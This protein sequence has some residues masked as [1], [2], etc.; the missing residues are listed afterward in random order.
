VIATVTGGA[1]F[2]GHHLVE[3][4]LAGG[5]RVRV[6]DDLSTGRRARLPAHDPDCELVVASI[7]D[8]AALDEALLGS[9]V[10]FHLAALVSVDQSLVEPGRTNDVNAGGTIEVMRAAARQH[11]HRVVLASSCA[12][13]GCGAQLPSRETQ[14]PEPTSP[15]GVAKLAAEGYL[16]ALGQRHGIATVALRY[17]NVFGEG[18]DPHS[19]YAAVVPA[20]ALAALEGRAPV[21]NGDTAITRD[22]VHVDDIVRANLLAARPYAP[23]GVTCN[24]AT[25]RSRSLC[26]L[27]GAVESELGHP[28]VPVIGPPRPGDIPRSEADVELARR[29]LGY[30]ADVPFEA[31]VRRTVRWY[32]G[33]ARETVA[34]APGVLVGAGRS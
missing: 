30:V 31:A 7:L 6:I 32:A 12:V 19:A 17:F 26:D 20:F 28:V 2:I 14:R 10:V 8:P 3:R 21:V 29:V 23:S 16:H 18:Q 25:G 11:V 22:Y 27:L 9:D 4:L 33:H 24:I 13:Y 5:A 34:T 15:Y 1:G